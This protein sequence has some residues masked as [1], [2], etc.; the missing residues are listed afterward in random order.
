M[1]TYSPEHIHTQTIEKH[2]NGQNK[3]INHRNT[4][5]QKG[6]ERERGRE[7]VNIKYM[8]YNT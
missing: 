8:F 6:K 3:A 5:K 1:I 4:N 2:T 7:R